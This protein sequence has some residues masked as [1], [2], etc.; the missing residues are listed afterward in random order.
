MAQAEDLDLAIDGFDPEIVNPRNSRR[1]R[2]DMSMLDS[3]MQIP[4]AP[5]IDRPRSY[6]NP[7]GNKKTKNTAPNPTVEKN[8]TAAPKGAA[9]QEQTAATVAAENPAKGK[10]A[11]VKDED[12][13]PWWDRIAI[14]RFFKQDNTR[15]FLGV[16][17]ILLSVFMLFAFISHVK[18]GAI[19]Q[20]A[21]NNMT[22]SEM[23]QNPDSVKNTGGAFGAWLSQVMLCDTLGVGSLPFLV[24]FWLLALGLLGLKKCN[25]WSVTFKTLLVSIS[26][27]VVLGFITT[28]MEEVPTVFKW[29]GSHGYYVN[30]WLYSYVN[31]IG[32]SLCSALLIVAVVCV[33]LTELTNAWKRWRESVRRRRIQEELRRERKRELENAIEENQR[34]EAEEKAAMANMAPAEVAPAMERASIQEEIIIEKPAEETVEEEKSEPAAEMTMP[35]LQTEEETITKEEEELMAVPQAAAQPEPIA[36]VKPDA[37]QMQGFSIDPFR[38]DQVQ[39]AEVVPK[40][41]VADI[42]TA[43]PQEAQTAEFFSP[44]EEET[45]EVAPTPVEA[46]P[47]Q[48]EMSVVTNEIQEASKIDKKPDHYNPHDEFKG[49]LLPKIDLLEERACRI[50]VDMNEQEANKQRIVQTLL[51][52]NIKISKIDATVGPTVTLYEV[53]PAEGVRISQIQRLENDIALSLSALGIRIIAPIP[54]QG[55]V[56]IEVPNNDPQTVSIRSVLSSQKYQENRKKMNL[57]MAMGATISNEIFMADLTKMPHM[58]VAGATGMGKSV[59]LNT[60]LASLLYSKHPSE[61]KFVLIDPKMVEFSLYAKIERYFLAKLPGEEDT[62][63]TDPAKVVPTLSSLCIE[64]DNRYALLKDAY[65]RNLEDYNQKFVDGLLDTNN[66]H[67]YLPYIVVVVDEFADLIMTSGKEVEMP[68]SRITAKARAVGIH[69]IL[70]TQRPTTNVITGLIKANIPGRI[71]FRVIQMIDSRTILD[72]PGANQLIGKGDMLFSH[73]GKMTRVQCAFISTEEVE[74]IVDSIY[75]QVGPDMTYVLPEPVVADEESGKAG[76]NIGDRDAMFDDV[77]RFIVGRQISSV[78]SLQRQFGIGYNR[79][80]RLMDQMEAAGIVGRANGAKPR[81]ILV[82]MVSLESM[83]SSL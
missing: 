55:A 50:E 36:E 71:A 35:Q 17:L 81:D 23:A 22:L 29:G 24:Y 76:A 60:I 39:P 59:G 64:M 37:E 27:S 11:K 49:Y 83:L 51:N 43:T 47:E 56:G 21:V 34:R 12:S 54:G 9:I 73:N 15:L 32:A 28:L 16:M 44:A 82:D 72:C 58:L 65:V 57:P 75:R 79:A 40:A 69:M 78:S 30:Q 68:I 20:S 2:N 62:I 31:L 13:R 74:A 45:K 80:G 61:L 10:A 48:M 38:I 19:D 70:A 77:A 14:V 52:Y 67:R 5:T 3:S 1:H 53:V 26:L 4:D 25:F 6:G 66:G 33:Y 8:N 63:I 46:K 18:Y 42:V 41:T 7:L